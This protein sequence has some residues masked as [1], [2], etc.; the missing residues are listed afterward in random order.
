M[1]FHELID[2]A[3][4]KPVAITRQPRLRPK[5]GRV[6]SVTRC[7]AS[8]KT[9]RRRCA[10]THDASTTARTQHVTVFISELGSNIGH[11]E[12]ESGGL[13]RVRYRD[14]SSTPDALIPM[15]SPTSTTNLTGQL[16]ADPES[17][18]G[19]ATAKAENPGCNY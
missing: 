2:S 13:V 14:R 8:C 17:W 6:Q 12:D 4:P 18:A 19:H 9:D 10:H 16:H 15:K 1:R 3:K 5:E 7:A 11:L